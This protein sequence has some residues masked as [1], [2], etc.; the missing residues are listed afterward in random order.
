[1]AV[2]YAGRQQDARIIEDGEFM[3]VLIIALVLFVGLVLLANVAATYR[4]MVGE[5]SERRQKY[6]QIV[7]IWLFPCIGAAIV[8]AVLREP[9]SRGGGTY[10]VDASLKSDPN[11]GFRNS[12]SDYFRDGHH[13]D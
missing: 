2:K 10:P 13:S 7:V 11:L 12:S 9:K 8:W 5:F 1:M 3:N 6:L 4:V